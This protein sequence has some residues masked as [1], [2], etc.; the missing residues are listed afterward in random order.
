MIVFQSTDRTRE[1]TT[2]SRCGASR[3]RLTKGGSHSIALAASGT[4]GK[5]SSCSSTN[6]RLKRASQSRT[7]SGSQSPG[8]A[9]VAGKSSSVPGGQLRVNTAD[10]VTIAVAED[11]VPAGSKHEE[12]AQEPDQEGI[13]ANAAEAAGAPGDAPGAKSWSMVGRLSGLPSCGAQ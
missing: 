4:P 13:V 7:W 12:V 8:S 9:P 5:K 2:M 6:M 3:P 1:S 11:D 10:C